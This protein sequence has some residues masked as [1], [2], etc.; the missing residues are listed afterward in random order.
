VGTGWLPPLPDL[1]DYTVHARDRAMTELGLASIGARQ[2][3]AGK[4]KK[5][6]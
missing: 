1:R 6:L 5:R 2:K 3:S 4:S